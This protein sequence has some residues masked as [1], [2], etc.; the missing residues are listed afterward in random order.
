MSHYT[1]INKTFISG[2]TNFC[3]YNQNVSLPSFICINFN[4]NSDA[5][6]KRDVFIHIYIQ[7]ELRECRE[8]KWLSK[9]LSPLNT[10]RAWTIYFQ[11]HDSNLSQKKHTQI[12]KIDDTPC[13]AFIFWIKIQL[14]IVPFYFVFNYLTLDV[15]HFFSKYAAFFDRFIFC[16][17]LLLLV[18]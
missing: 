16:V 5:F 8:K 14:S 9:M 1:Q 15:F 17:G 13:H 2:S 4:T 10:Q 6:I 18:F 11:H 7:P 12:F 3:L